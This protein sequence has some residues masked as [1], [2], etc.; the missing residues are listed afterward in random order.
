MKRFFLGAV[1]L[2]ALASCQQ[3]ANSETPAQSTVAPVE[4]TTR[5]GAHVWNVDYDQS[6]LL[7]E[8]SQQTETFE[9]EF[10]TFNAFIDLNPE[11]TSSAEIDVTIDLSSVSAGSKDR[12]GAL[13][14]KDWFHAKVHPEARFTS[15]DVQA[16]GVGAYEARGQLS[17][18]GVSKEV[19]LPFTLEIDQG[20]ARA[21]GQTVINRSDFNVGE[22]SFNTDEWVGF[23]VVV[24]VDILATR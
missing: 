14:G 6:R 3:A 7:F 12:D 20:Q 9:G 18:K 23:D 21:V 10:Q 1:A 8:A 5:A 2:L 16:M 22:G 13:P 19:V 11:D 15:T 4:V 17:L 24:K